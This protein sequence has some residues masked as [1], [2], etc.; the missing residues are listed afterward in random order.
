M[1]QIIFFFLLLPAWASA[2]PEMDVSWS[3]R[4]I[5]N[6]HGDPNIEEGGL[7]VTISSITPVTLVDTVEG[8]EDLGNNSWYYVFPWNW[9]GPMN[10]S[11]VDSQSDTTTISISPQPAAPFL[12]STHSLA[13]MNIVTA[14]DNL[15]NPATGIYAFGENDNCLQ[16][17]AE[18]ERPAVLQWYEGSD[19]PVFVEQVGLRI[20]GGWSR[21]LDQKGFKFYF[22]DYGNSDQIEFDFFGSSPTSFRRLLIRTGRFPGRCF[23]SIICE[24]IF[25]DLG[26]LGSRFRDVSVFLNQEYWGFYTLRE[27]LD[28][29]FVEHTLGY[30]SNDYDLI[31]D[32]M[33]VHGSINSWWNFL[34]SFETDIPV[35][36]H[37][38][39][40]EASQILDME[41]FI[42]WQLIN[43]FVA[44]TDNNGFWNLALL[45]LGAEPWQFVMW[46]EDMVFIEINIEADLFRFRSIISEAEF[47]EFRPPSMGSGNMGMA[48]RWGKMFNGLM[49]NSEFKALFRQRYELLVSQF[50]NPTDLQG[51][52]D[53]IRASQWPEMER[54]AER[55]GWDSPEFYNTEADE[56]IVWINNREAINH[57]QYLEFLEYHRDSVELVEFSAEFSGENVVLNWQTD[58]EEEVDGFNLYRGIQPDDLQL[59]STYRTNPN[60]VGAGGIWEAATYSFVDTETPDS[61][62]IFYRLS[63][64]TS[65]KQE[66]MLNWTAKAKE[67]FVIPDLVINE[68]LALNSSGIVDETGTCEDWCEI[69]NKSDV[70]V[71]LGG[72]YLTD[73]LSSPTKW[74]FPDTTIAAAGH[75]LVWCDSDPQD[76]PLHANF[77]LSANGEALAIFNSEANGTD[78]I[79]SRLF[80][81]Q[82]SDVSEGL[83]FDGGSEF[84]FFSTP[85]PGQPNSEISSTNPTPVSGLSRLLCSPNPFNPITEISFNLGAP[86]QV[87]IAIFSVDGKIQRHLCEGR[88]FNSGRQ[89]VVW[90]GTDDSGRKVP[91]GT[92]LTQ[93]SIPGE[94][95]S[96]KMQLVK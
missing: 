93:V 57:Q 64:N 85:T 74:A 40:E 34:V 19:A 12:P 28:D 62:E 81:P 37:S 94:K 77:K 44:T 79:D 73:D 18:W 56:E 48:I 30:G 1:K 20:N 54:H 63:S 67:P 75:L 88:L 36:S 72:M 10:A 22:D 76:G 71:F 87:T 66:E 86:V 80:G 65:L 32:G 39:Y 2:N 7:G 43:I 69:Y 51:R 49:Q 23:N 14:P 4:I 6:Y 92:Y 11:F 68:Y 53:D 47:E 95:I 83:C 55:W 45:R 42:D 5:P 17:G 31:K 29:E 52:F 24:G 8:L 84:C 35:S 21:H 60:L 38:W 9:T 46:D 59:I 50:L 25:M 41:S 78:L 61:P 91:S 58:S 70:P 33:A 16:H 27:R 89:K 3:H 15:W 13:V 90:D 82:A 26:H 96:L